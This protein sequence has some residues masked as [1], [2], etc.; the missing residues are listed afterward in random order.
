MRVLFVYS[1][2]LDPCTIKSCFD[3]SYGLKKYAYT[4][5]IYYKDL[6]SKVI[7]AYDIIIFQ[8]LGANGIIIHQ[9]EVQHIMSLI[10]YYYHSKKFIY[11]I[12][13]L[14]FEDQN[15]LPMRL[16]RNC[17]SV[18]CPNHILAKQA[19]R[20]NH[21]VYVLR[22]YIDMKTAKNISHDEPSHTYDLAWISTGALGK[23]LVKEVMLRL[24]NMHLNIVTIGGDAKFL[25][26]V[27]GV[28]MHQTM[29]YR[30]MVTILK[31]VN[32]LINPVII[33]D[34]FVKPRIEKRSKRSAKDFFDCKS[35]IKYAIAGGTKTALITSKTAPYL[36]AVQ[37]EK[38][39]LFVDNKVEDWTMAIKRLYYHRRLRRKII[40]NAYRDVSK[41]YTLEHGAKCAFDIL[42]KIHN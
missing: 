1:N 42:K 12:D 35:E 5:E 28:T 22:T 36:Y 10:R 39:G 41:N 21:H 25:K 19:K 34:S 8:R 26:N 31:H 20:Y 16:M 6:T 32:I 38:N 37:H 9:E 29:P 30:D 13:D 15:G 14:L 17:H 2:R 3:L 27:P 4:H 11:M 33:D 24:Q 23:Q 40:K 7:N 18:I